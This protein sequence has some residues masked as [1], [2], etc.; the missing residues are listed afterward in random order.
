MRRPL[1]LH[2]QRETL[3][4]RLDRISPVHPGRNFSGTKWARGTIRNDDCRVQEAVSRARVH[5]VWD[6]RYRNSRCPR[7]IYCAPLGQAQHVAL[8]WHMQLDR[9]LK[10]QL[11]PGSRRMHPHVYPRREPVQG[12][13][14]VYCSIR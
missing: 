14:P 11:H 2:P 6:R 4:F 7:G 8:D 1:A 5:C 13:R 12:K 3:P 10:R 9:W